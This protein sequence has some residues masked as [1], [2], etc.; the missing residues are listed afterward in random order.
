MLGDMEGDYLTAAQYARLAKWLE[1]KNRS[2]VVLGGYASFGPNGFKGKPLA[3]LLPV[4]FSNEADPQTDKRFTLEL[5]EK[6]KTHP[7]FIAS[8]DTVLSQKLW[9]EAPPLEGMPL[10]ARAKP[11][12]DVLAVNPTQLVEGKPAVAIASQRAP[13][14]GQVLVVCPD[15]TWTWSRLPRILGQDDNLYSRF[16]SQ[17]MRWLVGRNMDD[18]R[19]MIS[20]RTERPDYPVNGKVTVKV[21]RQRRPGA[22][23]AGS[24]LDVSITDPKGAPVQGLAGKVSAANPDETAYDF[25]PGTAGRYE[26]AASLKADG[27]T[28]ANAGGEVL[29]RGADLELAQAGTR[30]DTLRAISQATG[31]LSV[32]IEDAEKAGEAVKP[33]E[34]ASVRTTRTEFWNSP[35]L[36]LAFVAAVSVEWLLRRRNHLV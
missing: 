28:L 2:L 4:V 6:G 7:A 33:V 31:G 35:W 1:G 8:S 17:A 10:V 16:W 18:N 15:T 22:E 3:D 21:V 11:G 32:D 25:Y 29:V 24:L 12:A 19:P 27:K 36:F 9:K 34:R 13:G 5:T 14:G 23:T 26:I 30:P 20:V